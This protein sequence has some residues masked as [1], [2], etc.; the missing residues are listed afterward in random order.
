MPNIRAGGYEP[1][2]ISSLAG[3]EDCD[4]W[5]H[6][7]ADNH[8]DSQASRAKPRMLE[9]SWADARERDR[10]RDRA[11]RRALFT[12]RLPRFAAL[13]LESR[14]G[15]EAPGAPSL[16]NDEYHLILKRIGRPPHVESPLRPASGVSQACV[17]GLVKSLAYHPQI[18]E[19]HV[20]SDHG[21]FRSHPPLRNDC[22][23]LRTVAAFFG[24]ESLRSSTGRFWRPQRSS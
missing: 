1:T 9:L 14:S 3:R 4:I 8:R 23:R 6:Q 19:A 18:G 5:S 12:T 2:L 17:S 24:R 13:S 21:E 22:R 16:F 15:R 7:P 11:H 10:R 20:A